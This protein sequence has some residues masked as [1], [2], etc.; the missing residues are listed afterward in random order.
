MNS[1]LK[2]FYVGDFVTA[3]NNDDGKTLFA[4]LGILVGF[5]NVF[6]IARGGIVT[7]KNTLTYIRL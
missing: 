3:E 4:H 2:G 1:N 7:I 6:L 5:G